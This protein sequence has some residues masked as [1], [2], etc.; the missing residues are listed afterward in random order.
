MQGSDNFAR[1]STVGNAGVRKICV[2]LFGN[3]SHFFEFCTV[4]RWNF[5]FS[6]FLGGSALGTAGGETRQVLCPYPDL[7]VSQQ[8]LVFLMRGSGFL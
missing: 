6:F 7:P 4:D 2:V 3:V 8:S 5:V 1:D